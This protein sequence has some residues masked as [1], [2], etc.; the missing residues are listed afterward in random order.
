MERTGRFDCIVV[1][2]GPAGIACALECVDVRLHI[3][4]IESG[5]TL[6]G[7]LRITP[8]SIKNFP[9]GLFRDGEDLRRRMA[10]MIE[11]FRCPIL[12]GAPV[13]AIDPAAMAVEAGGTRHLGRTIVIATGRRRRKLGLD[14]EERLAPLVTY[15]IQPDPERFRGQ[16]VAVVGGGDNAT[17]DA[18]ELASIASTVHL[19][20]RGDRLRAR[21]DIQEQIRREGRIQV[22]LRA[23]VTGIHGRERLEEITVR[24]DPSGAETRLPVGALVIEVGFDPNTEPFRGSVAMN[25]TGEILVGNDAMTSAPGIFA[26]GDVVAGSY[27]RLA[28]AVGAGVRVVPEI[29]RFLLAH[30]EPGP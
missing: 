29:Q 14:G 2:G 19:I 7:Q 12:L 26:V 10:E 24:E 23:E 17:L 18:L 28:T 22:H 20:H 1:G 9:A 8:N 6:G 21:P 25:E 16:V 3:L 11:S 4:L 13:T 15:E 27:W 5:N 30:P